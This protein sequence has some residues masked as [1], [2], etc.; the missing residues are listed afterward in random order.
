MKKVNYITTM[1]K[2]KLFSVFVLI[3][4][5]NMHLDTHRQIIKTLKKK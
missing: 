1:K 2:F 5:I 3:N 4:K